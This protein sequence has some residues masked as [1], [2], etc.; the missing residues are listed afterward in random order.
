MIRKSTI[1]ILAIVTLVLIATVGLNKVKAVD[2]TSSLSIVDKLSEKFNLNESDVQTVFDDVHQE[3]LQE[4]NTLR[5]QKLTEA[6]E[7]GTITETQKQA[8]LNKWQELEQE[9]EQKRQEMQTWFEDQ[10]IDE[11]KLAPYLGFGHH[12]GFHQGMM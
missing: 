1:P 10:G 4:M 3:R 12:G 2:N 8:L 6:V 7:A 11:T 5:E 9:R